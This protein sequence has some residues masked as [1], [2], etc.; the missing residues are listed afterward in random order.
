MI[1]LWIKYLEP[2][3]NNAWY[4]LTGTIC[5]YDDW[6]DLYGECKRYEPANAK[7]IGGECKHRSYRTC[8]Y[9]G[10]L[11]RFSFAENEDI[12]I[13]RKCIPWDLIRSMHIKEGEKTIYKMDEVKE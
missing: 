2:I 1:D 10:T 8:F 6:A 3:C 9:K 7:M 12:Q 13:G 5:P 11:K 4:E